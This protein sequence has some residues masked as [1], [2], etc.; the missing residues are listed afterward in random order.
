MIAMELDEQTQALIEGIK[1]STGQSEEEVV[2][3]AVESRAQELGKTLIAQ[4]GARQQQEDL[5]AEELDAE[6]G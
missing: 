2:R 5:D 1:I 4:Q 3:E 6:S